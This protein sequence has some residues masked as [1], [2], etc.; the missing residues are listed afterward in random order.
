MSSYYGSNCSREP[1]LQRTDYDD[2]QGSSWSKQ[3][4]WGSSGTSEGY[5]KARSG[6]PEEKAVDGESTWSSWSLPGT[7]GP[8]G[9]SWSGSSSSRSGPW[10]TAQSWYGNSSQANSWGNSWTFTAAETSA[11]NDSTKA[12]GSGNHAGYGMSCTAAPMST[13]ID[14]T[15]PQPAQRTFPS[16]GNKQDAVQAACPSAA[17]VHSALQTLDE[18]RRRSSSSGE[19]PAAPPA[20]AFRQA[21]LLCTAGGQGQQALELLEE[22]RDEFGLEPDEPTFQAAVEACEGGEPIQRAWTL[23]TEMRQQ[24]F[25]SDALPSAE[26][27]GNPIALKRPPAASLGLKQHV[28]AWLSNKTQLPRSALPAALLGASALRRRGALEPTAEAVVQRHH[29]APILEALRAPAAPGSSSASMLLE[30][31]TL[32]AFTDDA[33]RELGLGGGSA[34]WQEAAKAELRR[35]H[36]LRKW[37]AWEEENGPGL[38][39]WLAYDLSGAH[40]PESWDLSCTGEVFGRAPAPTDE[41]SMVLLPPLVKDASAGHAERRALLSL[42]QRI[43]EKLPTDTSQDIHLEGVVMLYSPRPPS[44]TSIHAMRQFARLFSCVHLRA[45]CASQEEQPATLQKIGLEKTA[46]TQSN[47]TNK[48]WNHGWDAGWSGHSGSEA[49][50]G[51]GA[52]SSSWKA[53]AAGSQSTGVSN[54]YTTYGDS[55][56]STYAQGN[57]KWE[58]WL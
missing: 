48:S 9:S 20:A 14:A 26:E 52:G 16:S 39:A 25:D 44:L 54:G 38:L 18:A 4:T 46:S 51:S 32:G 17:D 30:V 36:M 35:Q 42:T 6:F 53:R 57:E 58:T 37:F 22:M 1:F 8:S 12:A 41:E 21:I 49:A 28:Q 50:G 43:F 24:G 10:K 19:S 31:P 56:G 45:G 29:L 7:T 34:Q 47:G 2:M 40:G 13:S 5:Y 23:L 15:Q 27:Q 3:K 33:Y 11:A 55:K